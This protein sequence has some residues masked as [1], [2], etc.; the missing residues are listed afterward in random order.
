MTASHDIKLQR[1]TRI[2]KYIRGPEQSPQ[3][4]TQVH[5]PNL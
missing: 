1:G 5:S 2:D 4:D 3:T